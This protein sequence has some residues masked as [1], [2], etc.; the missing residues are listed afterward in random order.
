MTSFDDE[1]KKVD[2]FFYKSTNELLF[3]LR[4]T[5]TLAV[6]QQPKQEFCKNNQKLTPAE[7]E[8]SLKG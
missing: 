7:I 1:K 6:R 3:S 8:P 5:T 2:P 4:L